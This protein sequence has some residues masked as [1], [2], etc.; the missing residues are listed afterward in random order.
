MAYLEGND[1]GEGMSLYLRDAVFEHG[2][3]I[4][5]PRE[6]RAIAREFGVDVPAPGLAI[7]LVRADWE[8]G[9]SRNV[10]G[11]PQ[12]F[13]GDRSWFCPSL[14]VRN[15]EGGLDIAVDTSALDGFLAAAF[16]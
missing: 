12:F 8:R 16:G 6:L 5:D 1:V 14:R 3:P 15:D 7:A 10:Q 2:R 13:M 11:S 9:R 4:D